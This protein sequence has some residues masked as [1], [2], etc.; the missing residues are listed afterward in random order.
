MQYTEKLYIQT[1]TC[2]QIL[3]I[4]QDMQKA[5]LS[6]VMHCTDDVMMIASRKK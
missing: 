5:V 4:V 2:T 3:S 6:T 1:C